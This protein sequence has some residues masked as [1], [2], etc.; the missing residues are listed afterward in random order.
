MLPVGGVFHLERV[1]AGLGGVVDG[2]VLSITCIVGA[3]LFI[4]RREK[5][6]VWLTQNSFWLVVNC[7]YRPDG[8]CAIQVYDSTDFDMRTTEAGDGFNSGVGSQ[9]FIPTEVS[10]T[11]KL[12]PTSLSEG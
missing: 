11:C 7:W 2:Y 3:V 12:H 4:V 6:C 10:D 5:A 1:V 8:A 9:R